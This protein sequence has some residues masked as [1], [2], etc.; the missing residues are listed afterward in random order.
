[1]HVTGHFASCIAENLIF[2]HAF[3]IYGVIFKIESAIYGER[4]LYMYVYIEEYV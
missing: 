4:R 1:M 2:I 3:L